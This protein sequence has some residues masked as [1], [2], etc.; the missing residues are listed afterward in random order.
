MNI[1]WSQ[2]ERVFIAEFSTDFAG[3]LESVKECGFRT[4]GPPSWIWYAPA[5]GVKALTRLREKKPKSG[6]TI[7]PEALT[8]YRPLAEQWAKNEEIKKAAAE[9]AKANKKEKKKQEQI[10]AGSAAMPDDKM[11]ITAADLPPMPPSE[12]RFIPPPPPAERCTSC[13]QPLYF[14][15]SKDLCLFCEKQLDNIMPV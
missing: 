9:L 5:P 3:D 1:A 2:S 8:I 7:S 12:N 10:A 4:F 15:E 6:L 11:F 13:Q 14:Y